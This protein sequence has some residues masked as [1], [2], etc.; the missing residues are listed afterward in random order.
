MVASV[1]AEALTAVKNTEGYWQW[2]QT[3]L[4]TGRHSHTK[5]KNLGVLVTSFPLLKAD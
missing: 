4:K 1:N 3:L 5:W 2:A